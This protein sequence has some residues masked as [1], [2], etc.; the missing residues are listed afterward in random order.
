MN[1]HRYIHICLDTQSDHFL[2]CSLHHH[3]RFKCNVLYCKHI[4]YFD[5]CMCGS[6]CACKKEW[7]W[8]GGC[9]HVYMGECGCGGV[10]SAFEKLEIDVLSSFWSK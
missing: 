2:L 8:V 4:R 9:T 1:A 3:C 7:E 10:K 6:M 5:V